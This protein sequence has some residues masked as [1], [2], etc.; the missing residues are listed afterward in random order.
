VVHLWPYA[1]LQQRQDVLSFRYFSR[2][3]YLFSIEVRNALVNDVAWNTEYLDVMRPMV[4]KQTNL[5]L[6][7]NSELKIDPSTLISK[8]GGAYVLQ[9]I[10][11]ATRLSFRD[12]I[13]QNL[14]LPGI[15]LYAISSN[16]NAF[17]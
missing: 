3:V 14:S 8:K 12:K 5:V 17:F 15:K 1:S 10:K 4:N 13:L 9:T 16:R 7:P 2:I 11:G 6:T